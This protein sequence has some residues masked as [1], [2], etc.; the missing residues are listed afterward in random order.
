MNKSKTSYINEVNKLLNKVKDSITIT[1][2]NKKTDT[3]T[4]NQINDLIKNIEEKVKSKKVVKSTKPKKVVKP[5][6]IVKSFDELEQ[7]KYIKTTSKK[8]PLYS[9]KLNLV[10]GEMKKFE[11]SKHQKKFIV[12]FINSA[13][14][15][16]LLFHGVGSG[17]TLTAVGFSNYYLALNPTHNVCII[18]PPS[19][20]YN[21]I[22]SM[23]QFGIDKRDSRYKFQTYIKFA[24]E[25]D[26][27]INEKSLLIIDEAHNF[28]SFIQNYKRTP[29]NNITGYHIIQ[30]CKKCDKILAMTGTPFVNTLTDIE[31]IMAMI[32]QRDPYPVK[33]IENICKSPNLTIDYFKYKISHFDVKMDKDIFKF[34]PKVNTQY[35]PLL[36]DTEYSRMY[37]FATRGEVYLPVGMKPEDKLKVAILVK[38]FNKKVIDK[39]HRETQ[40]YENVGRQLGNFINGI[41]EKYVLEKILEN[42]TYKTIIYTTFIE[43]SLKIISNKLTE[44]KIKFKTITGSENAKTKAKNLKEFNDINSKVMVLLISKAGTEG[45][46]TKN[47]R[48]IFIMEPPW[49]E[50]LA[51]QAIARAVRFKSHE[52]LPQKERFV[53]VYRLILCTDERNGR[54]VEIVNYINKNQNKINPYDIGISALQSD[55]SDIKLLFTCINKDTAIKNFIKVLD[56]K[57]PM[58]EKYSDSYSIQNDIIKAIDE[59]KDVKKLLNKQRT[60]MDNQSNKTIKEADSIINL[61]YKKLV[62]DSGSD[63]SAEKLQE[64][65]TPPEIAKELVTYSDHIYKENLRILEPSAGFGSLILAYMKER[66]K[67]AHLTTSFDIGEFN[68]D[69]RKVLKKLFVDK[70]NIYNLLETPNFLDY[71]APEPYDVIIM[72]PPFHLKKSLSDLDLSHDLFDIDFVRHAYTM[73]KPGGELLAITSAYLTHGRKNHK[74]WFEEMQK[75]GRVELVKQYRQ[76]KWKG[77]ASKDTEKKSTTLQL[78]FDI[79]KFISFEDDEVGDIVLQKE[80]NNKKKKLT[81]E[82]IKERNKLLLKYVEEETRITEAKARNLEATK[83]EAEENEARRKRNKEEIIKKYSNYTFEELITTYNLFVDLHKE[84][85][86]IEKKVDYYYEMK[87]IKDLIDDL[88]KPKKSIK[89]KKSKESKEKK[90]STKVE[91]DKEKNEFEFY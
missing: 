20:L 77:T 12:S 45:V 13:F 88:K 56:D 86:T 76:Y 81:P 82:E 90:K 68:P 41:K 42:P 9:E 58:I 80:E 49:S 65:F 73:L 35:V 91:K 33:V 44:N 78:N 50:S 57:V 5:K 48:Q 61:V 85:K 70:D 54:D 38:K 30:A 53:N 18:S 64:F 59:Q 32:N 55:S 24:Q 7:I 67:K 1:Q 8:H 74:L 15:G 28:R 84:A 31:N 71:V 52:A 79:W 72:N 34:Y 46:S 62:Q 51:E 16:C 39:S 66:E 83:E 23:E 36:L 10:D 14:K 6:P 43:N 89:K 75:Q 11:W 17:K 40:A 21:F 19:L 3:K 25:P 22:D 2:N 27:Y 63:K 37:R 87:I 29:R 69:S 26:N 47:C 4:T 60:L